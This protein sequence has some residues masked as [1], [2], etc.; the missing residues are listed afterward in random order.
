MAVKEGDLLAAIKNFSEK[1]A[2]IFDMDGLI[3]DTERLFMEQ[4]A[5]VMKEHGYV[6]TKKIYCETLGVGGETA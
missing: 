3:F 6:L 2:A 5:I 4:L 1:K